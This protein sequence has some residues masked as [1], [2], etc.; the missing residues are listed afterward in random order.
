MKLQELFQ[1]EQQAK[2]NNDSAEDGEKTK[3][4]ILKN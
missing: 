3:H 4:I 1:P 2:D